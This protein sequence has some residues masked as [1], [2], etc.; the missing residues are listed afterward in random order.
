MAC[1]SGAKASDVTRLLRKKKK[2]NNSSQ[3]WQK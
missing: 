3:P 2:R 1:E